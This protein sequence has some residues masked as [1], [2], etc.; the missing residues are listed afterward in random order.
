MKILI[1]GGTAEARELAGQLVDL[2][3]E[4]MTS[5]AGRTREP[6]LPAGGVRV[7]KFGG[8]PGLVGYLRATGTA[9]LV[10]ATHPYAGLISANAVVASRQSGVPLVRFMRPAWV[11]PA[12]SRWKQVADPAAAADS[13]P[14]GAKALI[15]TGHDGLAL[16]LA[17]DDCRLIVRQIGRAHV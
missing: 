5:F 12:G 2:G 4:V 17:R 3:H 14:S 9:R 1:L 7:G 15:S 16:F 13:L 8:I 6:R 11:E 10:D